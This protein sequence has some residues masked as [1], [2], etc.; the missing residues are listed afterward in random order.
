MSRVAQEGS[1]CSARRGDVCRRLCASYR[2]AAM[3]GRRGQLCYMRNAGQLSPAGL[4]G[5]EGAGLAC[6]RQPV[7][8]ARRHMESKDVRFLR[9]YAPTSR[10]SRRGANGT[11]KPN[12]CGAPKHF[13]LGW[14]CH[15]KSSHLT[16]PTWRKQTAHLGRD[17]CSSTQAAARHKA[18]RIAFL[19]GVVSATTTLLTHHTPR[20][21][22]TV[23]AYHSTTKYNL[24]HYNY[25]TTANMNIM[26]VGLRGLQVCNQPYRA[27]KCRVNHNNSG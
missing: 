16:F 8:G 15:E 20:R 25:H 19:C 5:V 23:T 3:S 2:Y 24:I 9:R 18:Q 26:G 4:L 1:F 12:H 17:V 14:C 13:W 27:L 6:W 22:L 11:E 10:P 7:P 21:R